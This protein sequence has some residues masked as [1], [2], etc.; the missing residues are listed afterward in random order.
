MSP[1]GKRLTYA[2]RPRPKGKSLDAMSP[3]S[4]PPPI[5]DGKDARE[6]SLSPDSEEKVKNI[7]T[8]T[9]P[10]SPHSVNTFQFPQ[11]SGNESG[12]FQP[13]SFTPMGTPNS[14]VFSP[15]SVMTQDSIQLVNPLYQSS[16]YTPNGSFSGPFS[17]PPAQVPYQMGP[18]VMS[19]PMQPGFQGPPQLVMMQQVPALQQPQVPPIVM[20]PQAMLLAMGTNSF[21]GILSPTVISSPTQPPPGGVGGSGWPPQSAQETAL[22]REQRDRM[23]A[24]LLSQTLHPIPEKRKKFE[25]EKKEVAKPTLSELQEKKMKEQEQAFKASISATSTEEKG[26]DVIDWPLSPFDDVV[27][28]QPPEEMPE[29][30]FASSPV[31]TATATGNQQTPGESAG[32]QQ[33][34]QLTQ[35]LLDLDSFDAAPLQQGGTQNQSIESAFEAPQSQAL[36]PSPPATN[37]PFAPTATHAASPTEKAPNPWNTF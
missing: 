23:F 16:P 31:A 10:F 33:K 22:Q 3:L 35:V 24:D 32:E 37:D 29:P 17:S 7:L 5:S 13:P 26:E 21:D 36:P 18:G 15:T 11:P 6:L 19:P 4:P 1:E 25:P 27:S 28:T 8:N 12:F 34:E 30:L 9:D 2:S 20:S 14:G